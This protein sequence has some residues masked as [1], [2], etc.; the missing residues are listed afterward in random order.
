MS[1]VLTNPLG[2]QPEYT[3]RLRRSGMGLTPSF[4]GC[5]FSQTVSG[6]YPGK[7]HL[8]THTD[9]SWGPTPEQLRVERNFLNSCHW[10]GDGAIFSLKSQRGA[11]QWLFLGVLT[12]PPSTSDFLFRQA[13][14]CSGLSSKHT[15]K[16]WASMWTWSLNA[17]QN[18]KQLLEILS[19]VA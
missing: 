16:R 6:H 4:S 7:Y 14:T 9:V 18:T 1:A 3:Y 10:L 8:S 2:I 13:Q 17:Q 5:Y 19:M 12:S 11:A 15:H